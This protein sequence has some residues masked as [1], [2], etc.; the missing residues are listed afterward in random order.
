MTKMTAN[1]REPV[2]VS[3]SSRIEPLAEKLFSFLRLPDGWHYGRGFAPSG[4]VVLSALYVTSMLRDL[5]ATNVEVFPGV[6]G[7]VLVSAYSAQI[8]IDVTI[9]PIEDA[10]QTIRGVPNPLLD[11]VVE[12]SDTEI[13]C[14]KS[15]R[16][17]TLVERIGRE[18]WLTCNSSGSFTQ[19]IT[20]QS[21]RASNHWHSTTQTEAAYRLSANNA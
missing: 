15:V 1:Y 16:F 11:Y 3:F 19:S 8:C 5:G 2:T 9:L 10:A 12:Q 6:N 21:S 4:P 20:V 18:R 17:Y 7:T 14:G 13:A